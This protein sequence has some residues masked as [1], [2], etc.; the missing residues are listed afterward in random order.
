MDVFMHLMC[1]YACVW[2]YVYSIYVCMYAYVP[3]YIC[4]QV[5]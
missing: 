5:K 2:E 1:L 4:I 3:K